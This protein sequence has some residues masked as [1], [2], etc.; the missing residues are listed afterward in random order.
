MVG[1]SNKSEFTKLYIFPHSEH[2]ELIWVARHTDVQQ[3]RTSVKSWLN[4]QHEL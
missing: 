2:L 3:P 1:T 4:H